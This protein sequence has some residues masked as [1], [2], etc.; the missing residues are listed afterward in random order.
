MDKRVREEG[1]FDV[2]SILVKL[3]LSMREDK[4]HCC[5]VFCPGDGPDSGGPDMFVNLRGI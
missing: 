1:A 2:R 5:S 3:E 4:E